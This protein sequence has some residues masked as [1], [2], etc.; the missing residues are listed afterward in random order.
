MTQLL[1]VIKTS[2]KDKTKAYRFRIF[3]LIRG[4]IICKPLLINLQCMLQ[5]Y[6]VNVKNPSKI[7]EWSF[8]T[9]YYVLWAFWRLCGL[10]LIDYLDLDE[11]SPVF[12]PGVTRCCRHYD[13]NSLPPCG[14]LFICIVLG[15][16][17]GISIKYL[18][19]TI[20]STTLQVH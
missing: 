19:K 9:M 10:R 14:Q 8:L 5:I 6:V 4:Y 2:K 17:L 11:W 1:I 13:M 20:V 16:V 3:T 7:C 12:N 18:R 15:V